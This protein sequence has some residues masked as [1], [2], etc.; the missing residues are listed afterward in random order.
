MEVKSGF[1]QTEV[2]V[3]PEDWRL[4]PIG[5]VATT[6]ASGRSSVDSE[7]GDFPVYGSTGTIGQSVKGD[8]SGRAI[9]I[10]RVGANAGKLTVVDGK[11][12]VTDN[13]I[14][15]RIDDLVLWSY[16]WRQL[17]AKR[18]NSMVF[19][20]GQPLITGT[21]IKNLLIPFPPTRAEQEAI[22]ETFSDADAL[23]GSLEQLITKKRH[24]KQG[25]M[26]ELLTGKRR[27]PGF[28]GNWVVKPLGDL[29]NFSGG[30]SASRDQL[31]TDGHCYLHYGDIHKSV[32]TYIDVRAEH[33]DI[34]KLNIPLNC[35]SPTSMLA[36]GDVVFV[37]ASEDDEGTSKHVV[38]VNE[39]KTPYISGLHTIVAKS[40]T[41]D[42]DHLYRRYCFQTTAIKRQFYFFAVGT[43]VSGI[44]K[45]NIAKVTL[46]APS[47]SEQNA[48]ASILADMDAEIAELEEK[49][50]KT[51][52]LK[53]G[54]MQ[55]L[56]IG[57]I[58]LV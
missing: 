20:S 27:L 51:R 22:A 44:S 6:V 34:P 25:A 40:K 16:V 49:L 21:Q 10:A 29:F 32:K 41:D 50:V 58:C 23:I 45:T 19:G 42:L 8:Y 15:V 5:D 31:S 18:L 54:M 4:Q 33:Q 36:D 48:I 30:F 1:K 46:P 57:R 26:Q 2:G 11:Y 12:G 24:L 3:I 43:K 35:I 56:L 7:F 47:L 17:D 9:L 55:E 13:T 37:D 53:Q 28:T 52:S 14:I 39:G 38:I